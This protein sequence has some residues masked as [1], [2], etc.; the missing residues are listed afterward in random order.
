VSALKRNFATGILTLVPIA[1]TYLLFR[2]L[3]D[4]FDGILAPVADRAIGRHVPGLGLI[5]SL[6]LVVAVG[7]LASNLLG[8]K[9]LAY[10]AK[11]LENIPLVKSVYSAA[12]QMV[13]ALSPTGRGLTRVVL[14]EYPR[15]GI[16]SVG[17][18]TSRAPWGNGPGEF[19]KVCV[20]IPAA[21]N[22]TSGVMVVV[23]EAELVDPGFSVEEGV[24]LVVSGGFVSP[25]KLRAGAN[26]E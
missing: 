18:V 17:F 6:L 4:F 8:K 1:V 15:K 21:L 7:A 19:G 14:V 9:L 5:F 20:L 22:P 24:R 12:R 10:L 16:Y 3:F 2:W 13:T 26:Q 23:P 11:I 25:E